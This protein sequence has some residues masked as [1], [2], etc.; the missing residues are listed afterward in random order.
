LRMGSDAMTLPTAEEAERWGKS[1][2]FVAAMRNREAS[3]KPMTFKL[4]TRH[5]EPEPSPAC[6]TQSQKAK[7]KKQKVVDPRDAGEVNIKQEI[8]KK[9]AKVRDARPPQ[10]DGRGRH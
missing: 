3:G 9:K 5:D 1:K 4:K 7:A 8:Q 2:A 10:P 6:S